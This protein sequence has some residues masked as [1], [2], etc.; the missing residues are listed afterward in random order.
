MT[1]YDNYLKCDIPWVGEYP[2]HWS[3]VRIKDMTR[4]VVGGDWG[5]DPDADTD[6][7]VITVLR[8]ADM[9]EIYFDYSN[10]TVRKIKASSYRTRQVTDRT[11]LLEKS[12]GGEKQLVGRAA[13]PV[14]CPSKAI[15][16][17][18]MVKIE[19]DETVDIRFINFV[20]Y[21]LYR[22]NVLSPFIQQT[23]GIQNL[24]VSYSL[25][26]KI[27]MPT[28]PEQE[29]IADYLDRFWSVIDDIKRVKFGRSKLS[30]DDDTRN[31]MRAL[32]DYRDSIVSECVTGARRIVSSEIEKVTAVV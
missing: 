18:F 15:C 14:G 7:E 11:I 16:T 13:L 5:D 24:N 9:N 26:L 1:R 10:L 4:Q 20:F 3:L 17:N 6:G 25:A 27:A 21:S 2:A 19:F 8:V 28:G 32:I 22:R 23:T 31:Q 29:I 30:Y 12:G